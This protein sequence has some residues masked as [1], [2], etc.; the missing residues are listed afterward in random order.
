MRGE[1]G[2]LLALALAVAITILAV[3]DYL[4]H[5]GAVPHACEELHGRPPA[6][7]Q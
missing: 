3:T 6:P 7:P 2:A 5:P 1:D 4:Y